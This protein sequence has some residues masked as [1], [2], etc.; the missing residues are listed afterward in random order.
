MVSFKRLLM[1][2]GL[3]LS[4][5]QSVQAA[6]YRVFDQP[7][8]QGQFLWSFDNPSIF[9]SPTTLTAYD[10]SSLPSPFIVFHGVPNGGTLQVNGGSF[11]YMS[12]LSLGFDA[13]NPSVRVLEAFNGG[14]WDIQLKGGVLPQ[15]YGTYEL[16][17]WEMN[18][19]D[20]KGSIYSSGFGFTGS[21][22]VSPEP[23]GIL[24]IGIG[25]IVL[26]G[27]GCRHKKRVIV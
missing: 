10:F 25:V 16:T 22:T 20:G 9:Q 12:P 6:T 21:V 5:G 11:D 7:D 19:V 8:G 4:L 15:A 13:T 24:L 17:S 14:F 27:H 23:S 1:T 26:A 3:L 2:A 18:D